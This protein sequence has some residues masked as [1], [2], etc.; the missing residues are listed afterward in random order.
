[1]LVLFFRFSVSVSEISVLSP[2]R[3]SI[4]SVFLKYRF[5]TQSIGES[6]EICDTDTENLEKK[7]R[8]RKN[9]FTL[10]GIALFIH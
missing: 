4:E 3:F 2:I 1:M 8:H 5:D 7:Y 9:T 6:I 10:H